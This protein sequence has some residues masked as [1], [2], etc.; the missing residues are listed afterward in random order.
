MENEP[1]EMVDVDSDFGVYDNVELDSP[2]S[3]VNG[4]LSS[5]SES[6]GVDIGYDND[7]FSCD[8]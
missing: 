6:I 3:Y 7:D 2:V 8:F 4:V 1:I 5:I